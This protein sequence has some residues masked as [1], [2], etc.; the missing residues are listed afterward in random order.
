MFNKEIELLNK[1]QIEILELKN[2]IT[3]IK[4]Q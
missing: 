4:S 2:T 1:S 3:E